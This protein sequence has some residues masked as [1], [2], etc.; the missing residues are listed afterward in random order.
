HRSEPTPPNSRC[1]VE[2]RGV[3][4]SVSLDTAYAARQR[5]ENRMAE[6]VQFN[7]PDPRKVPHHVRGVGDRAAGEHFASWIPAYSTLYA[8]RGNRWLTLA[9]SV[10]GKTRPQRLAEATILARRSFRLTAH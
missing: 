8:V 1:E 4:V 2:G 7:A 9:Y 10:S 3:H 6:Q 5:Y